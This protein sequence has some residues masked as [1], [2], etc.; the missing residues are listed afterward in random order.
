[1]RPVIGITSNLR[2]EKEQDSP[3]N[4]HTLRTKY[5]EMIA[6]AGGATVI[7]P[8]AAE[9]VA[10]ETLARLDGLIL[11]GGAD[12]P[13]EFFGAQPHPRCH[14]MPLER[15]RSEGLWLET[16]QKL[17]APVLGICLGMQVMNVAAGGTLIQDLPSERPGARPHTG[18][19]IGCQHEIRIEPGSR[20]AAMAPSST[21]TITSSHHQAVDQLGENYHA[22]ATAEDGI[23][24]AVE[25]V[26]DGLLLGVQWHPERC[27]DQPNWLLQGFVDWCRRRSRWRS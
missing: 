18:P 14:Y 9:E 26:G 25:A 12:I 23:V 10:Q 21:V 4:A 24:E 19:G 16:A 5:A 17:Q 2:L 3:N 8:I 22:V 20:L 1:L 6:A 7:L 27:L 15:W 13:P 11:S